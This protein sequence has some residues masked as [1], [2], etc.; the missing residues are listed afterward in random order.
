MPKSSR[1]A[2]SSFVGRDCHSASAIAV[3]QNGTTAAVE[4]EWRSSDPGVATVAPRGAGIVTGVA[5]GMTT[6][7]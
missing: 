5:A 7:P 1:K 4:G 6:I 2:T 3:Y